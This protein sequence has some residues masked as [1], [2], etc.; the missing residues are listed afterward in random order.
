MSNIG[1]GFGVAAARC[2]FEDGYFPTH[3][4]L[5]FPNCANYKGSPE[6]RIADLTRRGYGTD[7]INAWKK[8][9]EE[10]PDD[11][12]KIE[13]NVYDKSISNSMSK[14]A[15][16]A[17]KKKLDDFEGW[18]RH[19]FRKGGLT[20]S[21]RLNMQTAAQSKRVAENIQN[22]TIVIDSILSDPSNIQ[23]WENEAFVIKQA[24]ERLRQIELENKRVE[25]QRL[26]EIENQDEKIKEE[27]LWKIHLEN[28]RNERQKL[29]ELEK[30]KLIPKLLELEKVK[31]IPKSLPELK[32]EIVVPSIL[33]PLA[34]IG[35]L[36][37]TTRS[38]K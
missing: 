13:Y 8:Y 14:A 26:Q 21:Q 1:S 3:A 19:Q 15:A 33:I 34:A 25:E 28:K 5:G 2:G 7:I 30:V 22:R 16:L 18:F 20:W 27:N 38:K 10:N 32:P 31:L 9:Y 24:E 37:Y 11:P 23:R 17:E 29:L 4:P 6:E 12:L 36:L 35:L